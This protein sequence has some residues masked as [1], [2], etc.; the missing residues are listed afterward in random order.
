MLKISGVYK[1]TNV[2]T[3]EFYI[4][5]STNIYKRWSSHKTRFKEKS[6][7][8]YNK[9]LYAAMR[10]YGINNFKFEILEEVNE[11]EDIFEREKIHI[12]KLDAYENGYNEHANGE[13]HG[14]A[15][16]TAQ[17]V[18]D[19][20]ERYGEQETKRSVYIDY[21]N[22]ISPRG[23][24]KIWNGYTWT[25][26]LMEVYTEENKTY[27]KNNTG[28][29]GETNPKTKLS[30][31]DVVCIRTRKEARENK[32]DVYEDYKDKVTFGSFKNIW[33]GYNWKN[34]A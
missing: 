14:R 5:C 31:A 27:H 13:N 4:G 29:K 9:L 2:I 6:S 30:N 21:S 24:H 3:N 34:I 33:Y 19:I 32:E 26:I 16:L 15:K 7:K 18:V 17:D 28:F 1:I 10:E 12:I 25:D 22:K 20:R 8:E 23:F 11:L